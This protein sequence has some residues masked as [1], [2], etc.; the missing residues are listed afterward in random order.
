[1]ELSAIKRE[2]TRKKVKHLR[3]EGAI[4]GVVFSKDS[5]K[6]KKEVT[7]ITINLKEFKKFYRAAGEGSLITLKIEGEKDRNVLISEIQKHPLSLD[8]THIS[9]FEVDMKE[10]IETKIPIKLINEDKSELVTSG[11]GIVLSILDEVEIRC[12]PNNIPHEFELDVT[13]ITELEG[14]LK[15]S[16]IKVDASKVSILTDSDE[17]I[18]KIDY[19][20]QLEKAV[21]ETSGDVSQIE[22]IAE[23]EAAERQAAKGEDKK[24]DSDKKD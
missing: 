5:S 22:V 19:A 24:N 15:V 16:D 21:E 2:T 23:K 17:V 7:N 11:Q 10:E 6:G 3:T 9:F 14:V 13:Q 4:P 12:L 20:Q 8:Q 1:M 18:V